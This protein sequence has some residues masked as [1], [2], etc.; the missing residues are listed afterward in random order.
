[1]YYYC[2]GAVSKILNAY[3]AFAAASAFLE[4]FKFNN[5]NLREIAPYSFRL[6]FLFTC[7]I[8]LVI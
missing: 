8:Y 7:S 1:M 4:K 2:T 5:A 6:V 3:N